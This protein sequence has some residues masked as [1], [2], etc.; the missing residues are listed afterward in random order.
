MQVYEIA[1]HSGAIITDGYDKAS[2]V[3]DAENWLAGFLSD[4][5]F[6]GEFKD[7]YD[8]YIDGEP[9]GSVTLHVCVERDHGYS[10]VWNKRQTGVK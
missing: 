7:D 9:S 4:D 1:D 10:T 6:T 8:L 5:G 3:E 2:V